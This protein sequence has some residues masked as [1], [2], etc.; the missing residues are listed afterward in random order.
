M[1]SSNSHLWTNAMPEVSVVSS[2]YVPPPRRKGS[3][4][5]ASLPAL[6]VALRNRLPLHDLY[7]LGDGDVDWYAEK[8]ELKPGEQSERRAPLELASSFTRP[9]LDRIAA[10]LIRLMVDQFQGPLVGARPRFTA[11]A[12]YWPFISLPA[13]EDEDERLWLSSIQAIRNSLYLAR[14]LGCRHVEIVAGSAIPESASARKR[15]LPPEEYRQGRLARLAQ[16]LRKVFK[17]DEW[18]ALFSGLEESARPFCCLEI[19]PGSSYLIS[20]LGAFEEFHKKLPNE[21][22]RRVLLN[23]DLAHIFLSQSEEGLEAKVDQLK[24]LA[25]RDL[26]GHMHLS[27]HARSHAADLTP[28]VYH[29]F[30]HYR[31][32]LQIAI[33]AARSSPRRFSGVIAVELEACNDIHEVTRAVSKTHRWLEEA[34]ETIAVKA[35]S[36]GLT[37]DAQMKHGAILCFDLTN[38]TQ[39]FFGE[40]GAAA[41]CRR[42]TQVIQEVCMRVLNWKGSVLSFTGD[43]VIAFFDQDHF[44]SE[45]EAAEAA[46]DALRDLETMLDDYSQHRDQL[47]DG[48]PKGVSS[49]QSIHYGTAMVSSSGRFRHQA[50]GR[51]VVIA[52]R[53][54]AWIK[55]LGSVRKRKGAKVQT[56]LTQDFVDH[57]PEG[58]RNNPRFKRAKAEELAGIGMIP[59]VVVT[60]ILPLLRPKF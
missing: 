8:A 37:I 39:G 53:V 11:L 60:E 54:C 21:I 38:S 44:S 1:S 42:L 59:V 23:A 15:T 14:A 5:D 16:G 26:L 29:F 32:F 34:A 12:T 35:S 18:D 6:E 13:E 52:T 30:A 2:W 33:Q 58:A 40:G 9:Q 47:V 36:G 51:D 41:S 55:T 28:G 43:G 56:V 27:D 50:I 31:E 49:R 22:S 7:F 57:L 48:F 20:S 17:G 4:S 24:R 45:A 19:E 46:Y 10:A 3:K 25:G